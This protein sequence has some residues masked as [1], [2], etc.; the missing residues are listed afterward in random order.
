[1]FRNSFLMIDPNTDPPFP[2]PPARRP[3]L[4]L[5]DRFVAWL[6][7]PIEFPGKWPADVAPPERYNREVPPEPK[8]P[9]D[10]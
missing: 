9:Q 7:K 1:M 8:L 6:L 10:P 4:G 5:M 3:R 2:L